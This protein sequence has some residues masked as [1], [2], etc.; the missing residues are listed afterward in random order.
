MA[1]LGLPFIGIVSPF[2]QIFDSD[3]VAN[4]FGAGNRAS[5]ARP[6]L[7]SD[8]DLDEN[9]TA[10]LSL[11]NRVSA[12]GAVQNGGEFRA[13]SGELYWVLQPELQWSVVSEWM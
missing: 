10:F 5:A 3:R 8:G 2:L 11:V 9:N 6:I 4:A 13:T 7:R 1:L 12:V